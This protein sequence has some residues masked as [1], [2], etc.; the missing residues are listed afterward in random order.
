MSEY[1]KVIELHQELEKVDNKKIQNAKHQKAPATEKEYIEAKKIIKLKPE[2]VKNSM[3]I[4]Q[5]LKRR[6]SV[7]TYTKNAVSFSALS[8]ILHYSRGIKSYRSN[9]YNLQN[10]PVL[11]S[12]SAGGLQPLDIYVYVSSVEGIEAGLYYYKPSQDSLVQLYEG[13]PELDLAQ[14]YLSDF[15]QYAP[16][17]LIITGNIRRFH[18]KYD[19]RGYRLLNVDCGILAENISLLAVAENLGSC[20]L[21]AYINEKVEEKLQ[22]AETEIPLLCMS[23]GGFYE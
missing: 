13:R 1:E 21:A 22:L 9:A 2:K 23:V 18:W 6:E 8:N 10:Y 16:V 12:P 5:L 17:N 4:I 20:M 19:N 11:Y 14:I 15:P 3:D 7:R